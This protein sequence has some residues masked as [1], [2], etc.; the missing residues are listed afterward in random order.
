MVVSVF[1]AK[2]T[3]RSF[4]KPSET[5]ERSLEINKHKGRKQLQKRPNYKNVGEEEEEEK[6]PEDAQEG[7][8]GTSKG[9]KPSGENEGEFGPSEDKALT[10]RC[11]QFMR[12]SFFVCIREPLCTF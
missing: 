3:I 1:Q 5:L 11:P 7:M 9:M 8:E 6:G 10:N 4:I 2:T 12:F